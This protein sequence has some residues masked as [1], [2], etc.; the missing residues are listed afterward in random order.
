MEKMKYSYERKS[1]IG[2]RIITVEFAVGDRVVA[3][4]GKPKCFIGT[5][6][7]C[8][9]D[10]VLCR[11]PGFYGHGGEDNNQKTRDY[12]Y[13]RPEEIINITKH[14]EKSQRQVYCISVYLKSG[15]TS[16]TLTQEFE[17]L[18]IAKNTMELISTFKDVEDVF[19]CDDSTGEILYEFK[20][21]KKSA[22]Q[23]IADILK[24]P[25]KFKDW[26]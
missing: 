20:D 13:V 14:E 9:H 22:I 8:K 11:F 25:D 7:E 16:V 24:S 2:D 5:V 18:E 21:C 3:I 6:V 17:N 1:L 26:R 4:G 15:V 19:I 10:S 23:T 12:W